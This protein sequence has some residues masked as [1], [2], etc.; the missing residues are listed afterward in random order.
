VRLC[1]DERCCEV[2]RQ[3][4]D[5]GDDV[6]PELEGVAV[7]IADRDDASVSVGVWGEREGECKDNGGDSAAVR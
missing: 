1:G 6:A 5:R 7:G 3:S 4:F 2:V